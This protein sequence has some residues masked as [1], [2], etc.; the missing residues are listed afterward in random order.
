MSDY[1]KPTANAAADPWTVKA[2]GGEPLPPG[3]YN[4][5]KGI[6]CKWKWSWEVLSGQHQGKVGGALTDRSISPTT[7]PGRLI[8]GM[9]G[10]ALTPG[11]NVKV[12]VESLVGKVFLIR[13]APGPKG[14]KPSVQAADLPP[15]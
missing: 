4:A 12:L 6:A 1:V 10:R 7:H 3:A 14:G 15:E 5:E 11:E 9:V 8:A 13:Q 2:S